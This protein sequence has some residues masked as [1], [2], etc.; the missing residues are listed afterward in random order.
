MEKIIKKILKDCFLDMKEKESAEMSKDSLKKTINKI[1]TCFKEHKTSKE[2]IAI[3][4]NESET[5]EENIIDQN[6]NLEKNNEI[7]DL[8]VCY[9]LLRNFRKFPSDPQYPW[10]IKCCL[11]N[12]TPCSLFLIGNNSIGKTSL[13]NA[14]EYMYTNNISAV[15]ERKI[16]D[17]ENYIIYGFGRTTI[18]QHNA[19]IEIQTRNKIYSN[20]PITEQLD[21]NAFFCSNYDIER[22][23]DN[24][25]NLFN[26]ILEQNG[27]NT[28]LRFDSFI[29]E[30]D[31]ETLKIIEYDSNQKQP[32]FLNF[33]QSEIE[34]C[35]QAL[36]YLIIN[37]KDPD[38]NFNKQELEKDLSIFY[39]EFN[40]AQEKIEKIQEGKNS[41]NN[42]ETEKL[43]YEYSLITEKLILSYK[44]L[45]EQVLKKY[46]L[47]LPSELFST[48][49][50]EIKDIA[51]NQIQ[52]YNIISHDVNSIQ[53]TSLF[54]E[55]A[56]SDLKTFTSTMIKF[57]SMY[58]YVKT[59][60]KEINQNQS[61][62][63]KTLLSMIQ[64]VSEE[65]EI[66][67]SYTNQN[68]PI[69]HKIVEDLK[70]RI[71][72]EI[73]YLFDKFNTNIKDVAQKILNEF[74]PKNEKCEFLIRRENREISMK[75]KCKDTHGNEFE[76]SPNELYN[77]FRF[78][79]YAIS[80]KIAMAFSMME[81]HKVNIP[82]IL[83]DV[84]TSI[85][86]E[87][88]MR[89]EKFIRNI[90]NCFTE[91][92]NLN[93]NLQL[94]IFTQDKLSISSFI[95]GAKF[96]NSKTPLN[97]QII[98]GR[99][100]EYSETMKSNIFIETDNNGNKFRNLYLKL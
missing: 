2:T 23:A 96:I 18:A 50:Q 77:T 34:E 68:I 47:P 75:V 48:I 12:A 60:Y 92:V 38:S 19:T 63:I 17:K 36:F 32:Y 87:N 65:N 54:D 56:H 64:S 78:K 40:K 82:I 14:I 62:T 45:L 91:N 11:D 7:Q 28:L 61:E 35:I 53:N 46:F 73:D 29:R 21:C 30:L 57:H 67:R 6:D 66:R 10:G 69:L 22:I 24:E 97:T 88:S 39:N 55:L 86:F 25:N 37:K 71:N 58:Q 41:L 83:D 100:F 26:Y 4:S 81:Y 42:I 27:G 84:F 51:N 15:R 72:I 95:R 70:S 59:K 89:I 43:K 80:F 49:G 85:D 76:A 20:P 16:N 44:Y 3:L 79:L 1:Y 8:R 13:F 94:I 99:L 98:C 52:K 5:E 90:Y 93:G 33:S 74:S 31:K 9:L